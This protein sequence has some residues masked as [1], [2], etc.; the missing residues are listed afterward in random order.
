M[1]NS[2]QAAHVIKTL[3]I[4]SLVTI[5]PLV[6]SFNVSAQTLTERLAKDPK[7]I[8]FFDR[9]G[10][11]IE[12]S[13]FEQ[14]DFLK[15]N[16]IAKQKTV[17]LTLD[18]QATKILDQE[19][20]AGI[21]KYKAIG[22]GGILIDANTGEIIALSSKYTDKRNSKFNADGDVRFNMITEGIYEI[23]SAAKL[24]T[25]ANALE[26][27]VANSNTKIDVRKPLK[28]GNYQINDYQPLNRKIT[29]DEAFLHSSNIAMSKLALKIGGNGQSEFMT[30]L[31]FTQKSQIEN[32]EVGTPLLP[33]Q[34]TDLTTASMSYGHGIAISPLQAVTVVSAFVNGGHLVHPSIVKQGSVSPSQH[35]DVINEKTSAYLRYLLALNVEKGSGTKAKIDTIDIGGS[36]SSAEKSFNGHYASDKLFTTFIAAFPIDAPR[37]VLMIMFDEPKPVHETGK[38]STAGWNAAVVAGRVVKRLL[39]MSK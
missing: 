19:I 9:N 13:N 26:R 21:E 23:G 12:P 25:I 10:T 11:K 27:G 5:S 39:P 18:I 2:F 33:Q 37:Y 36:T 24:L 22:A 4:L 32:M 7:A 16:E 28:I 3:F 1:K 17:N 38:F 14:L 34:H 8:E 20:L 31:G 29:L 15:G 6:L 30:K 35:N